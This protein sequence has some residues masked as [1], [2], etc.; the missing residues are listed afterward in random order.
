MARVA[1][2]RADA[3]DEGLAEKLRAAGHDVVRCPLIAIEPLEGDPIDASGY[4]WLIVTS[5]NGADALAGRLT[6]RPRR[7]AAVGPATAE[8]LRDRGLPVDFVPA[9]ASQDGLVRE[10]PRPTGRVL[11]A[12]AEG[13][14][15]LLVD[16]LGADFVPLYRTRELAPDSFPDADV[17]VVASGSAAR[18][19]AGTGSPARLVA[20]GPQTAAEARAAGIPVAEEAQR[21]DDDAVVAA[22]AAAAR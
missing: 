15:R 4:D 22:V 8:A 5:R 12:A 2:T 9:E 14:R 1:L 13:A 10:L 7:I 6:G 11:L 20:I 18:A 17:V 16:E 3:S 21:P 19:F